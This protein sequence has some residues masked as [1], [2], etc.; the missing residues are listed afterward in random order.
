MNSQPLIKLQNLGFLL[1]SYS[2]FILRGGGGFP[3]KLDLPQNADFPN[4][5]KVH[6]EVVL[7]HT[8]TDLSTSI[9]A[10]YLIWH[11]FLKANAGTYFHSDLPHLKQVSKR[12]KLTQVDDDHVLCVS[13]HFWPFWATWSFFSDAKNNDDN[14]VCKD[15]YNDFF[16]LFKTILKQFGFLLLWLISPPTPLP[17]KQNR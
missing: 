5:S 6:I 4:F 8:A 13:S 17:Q 1:D 9:G 10:L 7:K 2:G 12:P 15:N 16:T 14:D 11:Y 3:S